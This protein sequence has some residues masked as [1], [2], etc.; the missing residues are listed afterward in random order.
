L[1]SGRTQPFVF[2]VFS[3]ILLYRT[4]RMFRHCGVPERS[5]IV[6]ESPDTR[7]SLDELLGASPSI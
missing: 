5:A 4:F 2:G 7:G 1:P 3:I 6:A